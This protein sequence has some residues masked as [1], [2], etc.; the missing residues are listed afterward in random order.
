M[1]GV[2]KILYL[3]VAAVIFTGIIATVAT[4][5]FA[6]NTSF[7]AEMKVRSD[8]LKAIEALHAVEKCFFERSGEGS[9]VTEEFLRLHKN[10][11][12]KN[13]CGIEKPDIKVY[14]HD[15]ERDIKWDFRKS[16]DDPDHSSWIT[17]RYQN[18]ESNM[19]RLHVKI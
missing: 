13:V 6:G 7:D 12:I 17:I 16:F 2:G 4:T 1:K 19:G 3:M 8:S 5:I 10:E 11:E 15:I 18:G 14:V 9:I